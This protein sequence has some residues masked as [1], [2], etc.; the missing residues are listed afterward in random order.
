MVFVSG[1]PPTDYIE[2]IIIGGCF[3][4]GKMSMTYLTFRWNQRA[5]CWVCTLPNENIYVHKYPP[6]HVLVSIQKKEYIHAAHEIF[7]SLNEAQ[8]YLGIKFNAEVRYRDP[9]ED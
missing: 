5:A 9:N 4:E 2:I 7:E 3:S 8:N 6:T 1:C